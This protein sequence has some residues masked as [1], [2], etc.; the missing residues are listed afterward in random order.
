[1]NLTELS[2]EMTRAVAAVGERV[3]RVEGR[4]RQSA[5]GILW[6]G[7]IVVTA[8][9]VVPPQHEL[10]VGLPN[11][12]RVAAR[13]AAGDAT[14]DVAILE[15]EGTHQAM[16]PT[17]A[18]PAVGEFA[19][20][21]ARPGPAVRAD[22]GIITSS[23]P[24]WRTG[25]GADVSHYLEAGVTMYPGF[26]GGALTG[27]AGAIWGM[28]SSALVPGHAVAI[29]T[30]TLTR[31]VADLREHGRIRR[32][33]LG[34]GVQRATLPENAAQAVGRSRGL[35]V[36]GVEPQ[37]PAA[38]AGVF[39]GDVLVSLDGSPLVRPDDLLGSLSGD[40]VGRAVPLEIVRGGQLTQLSVTLVERQESDQDPYA[41][42]H[43]RGRW[44]RR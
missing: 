26:S 12:E 36:A 18:E 42:Q 4:R 34:V 29:P 6:E 9:H 38:A 7:G 41:G 37:S 25:A 14:T 15:I 32:G 23:E 31:V 11:G 2:N 27:V 44:Q 1:M 5:S 21:V 16:P 22:F 20:A 13:L 17:P 35:L 19:L 28:L 24:S 43:R 8:H 39:V 3:V 30:G 33:Y 10:A 40:R